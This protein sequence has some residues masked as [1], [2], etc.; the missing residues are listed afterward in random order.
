M[1][2]NLRIHTNVIE[3]TVVNVNLRQDFDFL[4]ILSLK[5]G[6]A[7]LY[8]LDQSN[9]GVIVGRVLANDAFGIPNAKV[10]IFIPLEENDIERTDIRS[11]Y[12]FATVRELNDKN[13]RYNLLPDYKDDDCYRTVGTFPNK[14]LVLDDN[15]VLEVFDKYYKYTT[16]TNNA[17]D[18][19]LFGV[20]TGQTMLHVDIDLSDIGVLS[21]KPRDFYYKGYNE[22]LFDNANQFKES[23]NLDNLTQII[24]QNNG[25]YVYPFFG[26]E[27]DDDVAIT[28]CDVQIQYKFEP[29]CVFFGSI[30]T[31]N[32][33]HSLGHVCDPAND[34]GKNSELIA[35]EGTIEM[36]RKTPDN[37]TEEYQIQG[38]KLIDGDGVWCY[39]IP[40][41]LDYVGTDEYGNIVATD[42]PNKG[43]PTRTRA[44]FRFSIEETETDGVSRHRAKYLVPNNPHIDLTKDYPTLLTDDGETFDKHYDFGSTTMEDDY[45]DLYWNCIYSVKNYIP[46]VQ[47]NQSD[48]TRHYT[49]IKGVNYSNNLNPVPFNKA[50]IRL[51]F[52]Y[53]VL[54]IIMTIVIY[55]I[56]FINVIVTLLDSFCIPWPINWC[57]FRFS[58]ISFANGLS[59][60]DDINTVYVPG[61]G[62][63]GRKNTHCPNDG[64]PKCTFS[65]DPDDLKD[66]I[67]QALA[68]EYENVNLDF[69]N[70]W[71]NGTLYF[72]LWFWKKTKKKKYF[73]GLF[74]KRAVNSYCNCDD[75]WNN[76]NLLDTCGVKSGTT[77]DSGSKWH[78]R[79][80]TKKTVWGLI[81]NVENKDGLNIYYYSCGVVPE[82]KVEGSKNFMRLFAT[83]LILLGSFNDCDLNGYPKVYQNLPPTT[84]NIPPLAPIIE[85]DGTSAYEGTSDEKGTTKVTGMDWEH[86]ATKEYPYYG[87]GLILGMDCSS[88]TTLTKTCINL[89]RLS[90]LGVSSDITYQ[91]WFRSGNNMRRQQIIND[92]FIT[93]TE[94]DDDESRAM[95]ATLNHNGLDKLRIDPNTGYKIYDLTYIFP[96]NF[97]GRQSNS[98]TGRYTDGKTKDDVD[99]DYNYFRFGSNKYI[100]YSGTQI[101]NKKVADEFPLYNN[102]YYFY[103]GLNYG[104]TAIEKFNTMFNARCFKNTKYPFSIEIDK[105]AAASSIYRVDSN[106]NVDCSDIVVNRFGVIDVSLPDIKMP[107]SY[108][109]SYSDGGVINSE[110]NLFLNKLVFGVDF[111][112]VANDYSHNCGGDD[113]Y[114]D[115]DNI[116]YKKIGYFINFASEGHPIGQDDIGSIR[117]VYAIKNTI[118]KLT[119]TD[120][121]DKTIVETI[122]LSQPTPNVGYTISDLGT[123]FMPYQ[124][125]GST[126]YTKPEDIYPQDLN[127]R[128]ALSSVTID[129]DEYKIYNVLAS[130]NTSDSATSERYDYFDLVVVDSLDDPTTYYKV[131]IQIYPSYWGVDS[132][133][134]VSGWTSL[135]NDA[136]LGTH[137]DFTDNM[138]VFDLWI[139]GT[140]NFVITQ[141]TCVNGEV[142]LGDNES[143]TLITV[144]NGEMFD[145]LINEVP[146]RFIN[147]SGYSDWVSGITDENSNFYNFPNVA[148]NKTVWSNYITYTTDE[149]QNEQIFA[150]NETRLGALRYKLISMFNLANGVYNTNMS[151][152]LDLDTNGGGSLV[153]KQGVYPTYDDMEDYQVYVQK[154]NWQNSIDK[155]NS[156]IDIWDMD[157]YGST[158]C[159]GEH[160][161][162]VANNYS[163]INPY[164]EWVSSADNVDHLLYMPV[165]VGNIVGYN[166]LINDNTWRSGSNGH[167]VYFAAFTNNAGV[168]IGQGLK[169]QRFPS[170]ANPIMDGENPRVITARNYNTVHAYSDWENWFKA[171]FV[172]KRI[173]YICNVITSSPSIRKSVE[174]DRNNARH[175]RMANGRMSCQIINGIQ[176]AYDKDENIIDSIYDLDSYSGSVL[177][178]TINPSSYTKDVLDAEDAKIRYNKNT[179]NVCVQKLFYGSNIV[180]DFKSYDMRS[181]F[182]SQSLGNNWMKYQYPIDLDDNSVISATTFDESGDT[183]IPYMCSVYN[184]GNSTN[185]DTYPSKVFYDICNIDLNEYLAFNTVSCSYEMNP[186]V[187]TID[188]VDIIKCQ[189]EDGER[190]EFA[191]GCGSYYDMSNSEIDSAIEDGNYNA[192]C[193]NKYMSETVS[194]VTTP[195]YECKPFALRFQIA[196]NEDFSVNKLDYTPYRP[197]IFK[198]DDFSGDTGFNLLETVESL[199]YNYDPNEVYERAYQIGMTHQDHCLWTMLYTPKDSEYN[200]RDYVYTKNGNTPYDYKYFYSKENDRIIDQVTDAFL[201]DLIN[202][203]TTQEDMWVTFYG[204]HWRNDNGAYSKGKGVLIGNTKYMMVFGGKEYFSSDYKT[205][206]L[207]KS[208]RAYNFGNVI[209]FEPVY[210]SG[211]TISNMV[212]N[213]N[214]EST[215]EIAEE[216]KTIT[217]SFEYDLFGKDISGNQISVSS[218]N[219]ECSAY[220]TAL[221]SEL[222]DGI[223]HPYNDYHYYEGT[224]SSSFETTNEKTH[225]KHTFTF[226]YEFLNHLDHDPND[227]RHTLMMFEIVFKHSN[228]LIYALTHLFKYSCKEVGVWYNDGHDGC[229]QGEL[230]LNHPNRQ[231]V[232]TTPFQIVKQDVKLNPFI[233]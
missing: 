46:R 35:A 224:C 166:P 151:N 167:G 138:L 68:Q 185:Y 179:E 69:Y 199:K 190:A 149:G 104:K 184:S 70:D 172:D 214:T 96:T 150:T 118:Y 127:G 75:Q 220:L 176:L 135:V 171:Y 13:I 136:C 134:R 38:N 158:T 231:S 210:T 165:L 2:K 131:R 19:M 120:A 1:N 132:D 130:G 223:E 209:S 115:S 51:R 17:G 24:T 32:F 56:Y 204:V 49:G 28:R 91:D 62:K 192:L 153:I 188:D 227:E 83:D 34:M 81:K 8:K 66:K 164:Y 196:P 155:R 25:V 90:E 152:S 6:Q 87:R 5:I 106:G 112:H 119:I 142:I 215:T 125:S 139:P 30:I 233:Q 206:N 218:D 22:S 98:I 122:S 77:N 4:E 71:L 128:I 160:P 41:N 14:R 198:F 229:C 217:F 107:Y 92:G 197:I 116:Y 114:V 203:T 109:I 9:Y 216:E 100:R 43:I 117:N 7:D 141:Y 113:C 18:Y 222:Y 58:C 213:W 89:N 133:L 170:N 183:R 54:C 108:T 147:A 80:E 31:D 163:T 64:K 221:N 146:I 200:I 140:F 11:V 102:S 156:L 78:K 26:D 137:V 94:I 55:I 47:Q 195:Y 144:S 225:N 186:T 99:K 23:T 33:K 74:S 193:N 65:D 178:Y 37:L 73:F 105:K 174:F 157:G 187:E 95:F 180:T 181:G 162:I 10:S 53:K 103:F 79:T 121:N 82:T 175:D 177:E 57:P 85:S 232:D 60:D 230:D 39:Q 21:Q 12:D 63:K 145:A 44:R 169:Y 161:N 189:V 123:K 173:S 191:I 45:R 48:T 86:D 27:E 208:V 20:P 194:G 93:N 228:G 101:V 36:I 159:D 59:E 111:D 219:Y 84:A 72:P 50:R 67:E 129:G 52:A 154:G 88:I 205:E 16:V 97:D 126:E 226:N 124:D 61:C 202:L 182:Y 42:N 212:A 3:D 110:N 15:V 201:G 40:M 211:F 168:G 143:S 207:V 76:L 148:T 29:T